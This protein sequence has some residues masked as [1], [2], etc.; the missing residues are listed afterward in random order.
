[1]FIAEPAMFNLPPPPQFRG[2]D[3]NKPLTVYRRNLPHWRQEGA[4][5]FVT[6][7]L[8]DALPQ[9]KLRQLRLLQQ[10]WEATHPPPRSDADWRD[11]ARKVIR[12]AQRYLDEGHGACVFRDPDLADILAKALLRF[13]DQR[14][15]TS[16]FAILPNHC[17]VVLQPFEGYPLET[18][19]QA[20]K[21]SVAHEVNVRCQK[22]GAL[23][24]EESYDQ[25]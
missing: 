24:Q 5:Y 23:W 18:I 14:Y 19:L 22:S 16:C 11:Y 12:H 7:R 10:Q 9:E 4:T 13:Q 8:A 3:P 15:F 25:I 20:C 17:H 6:F 1:P 21:G 2:L